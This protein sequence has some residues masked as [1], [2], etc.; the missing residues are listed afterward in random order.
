MQTGKKPTGVADVLTTKQAAQ[1]LGLSVTTVQKMVI[2]GEIEA[3]ITPGGH[4]RIPGGAVEKL[5]ASKLPAHAI[6]VQPRVPS[7][8]LR[9]LLAEDDPIQAQFFKSIVGR[10]T[11]PID[12][13]VATDASMALIQLER[14]RPDLLVTDLLM[15]PFDGFH[16]MAALEKEAAYHGIEVLILSV[17]DFTEARSLGSL[18][19]WVT[20]YQKP[21]IPDRMLGYLDAMH[22]RL[23]KKHTRHKDW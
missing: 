5:L 8:R 23:I 7:Q 12:L 6:A 13:T 3:W 10:C 18:P 16:L 22:S 17:L 11:F 2:Q 4:R 1:R 20:Y 19:E 21:V 9:V 14:Q 15:S